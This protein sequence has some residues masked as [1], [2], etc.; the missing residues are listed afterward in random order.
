MVTPWRCWGQ[1][2]ASRALGTL[3]I[4]CSPWGLREPDVE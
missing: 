1:Q 4:T 3:H 2:I